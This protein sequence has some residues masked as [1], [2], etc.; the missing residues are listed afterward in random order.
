[1]AELTYDDV[2]RAAQDAVR[3]IHGVVNGLRSHTEDIR[4]NVLQVNPTQSQNQLNELT[5]RL[6]MLQTQITNIDTNLRNHTNSV[7]TLQTMQQSMADMHRRL[8]AME[9]FVQFIYRYFNALQRQA[10]E[11]QD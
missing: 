1:M 2:R 5:N 11:D 9:E 6:N 3:D 7:Y 10:R 8:A 4:R